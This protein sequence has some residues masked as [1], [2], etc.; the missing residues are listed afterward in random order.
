MLT[1]QQAHA[2]FA[3]VIM[4]LFCVMSIP[5]LY[6]TD[7]KQCESTMEEMCVNNDTGAIN[8]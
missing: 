7:F 4:T 5:R 8:S 2:Q 1:G 3:L 6:L